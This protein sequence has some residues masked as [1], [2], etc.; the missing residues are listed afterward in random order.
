[1]PAKNNG[2]EGSAENLKSKYIG[3][4]NFVS[5]R[6]KAWY[7]ENAG[8]NILGG[9]WFYDEA[10]S[11]D[12]FSGE[13][14]LKLDTKKKRNGDTKLRI[15]IPTK[16]CQKSTANYIDVL[17]TMGAEPCIVGDD[18]DPSMFDGLLLPGGV[19]IDPALYG[20]RNYHC[21]TLNDR[22]DNLQKTVLAK[23][24]RA[25]K[26]VFG[27][28]RGMQLINVCFGGTLIQHI[29]NAEEHMKQNEKDSYHYCRTTVNSFISKIYGGDIVTNSAHHQAIGL[30]GR[31]LSV[32][33]VSLDGVA[34]E[35]IEHQLYPVYGVQ[36]HP[37]RMGEYGQAV[38]RFFLK[39]CEQNKRF[40]QR[41]D[42]IYMHDV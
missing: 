37:E 27:I 18:C 38:L 25:R 9:Q 39:Q 28:C 34:I 20:Q 33:Q 22:L 35:A 16:D 11:K 29:S 1:M 2:S 4:R 17:E 13:L 5:E 19:D 41:R 31:G 30:L 32:A 23:F 40:R 26:P 12:P 8:I 42:M 6:R 14:L 36:W 15:A 21:N 24:V 3:H 10:E 7:F